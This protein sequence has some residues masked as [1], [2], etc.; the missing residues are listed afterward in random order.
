VK[1][2]DNK[3]SF[4]YFGLIPFDAQGR[5]IYSE[6]VNFFPG[7]ETELAAAAEPGENTIKVK[8]AAKWKNQTYCV[9]AFH[10]KSDSRMVA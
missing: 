8:D 2:A 3:P 5:E 4:A 7:T 10:A 9:A 6:H 1:A